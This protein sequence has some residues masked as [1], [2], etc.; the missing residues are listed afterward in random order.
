MQIDQ[1]VELKED[2][3]ATVKAQYL[4]SQTEMMSTLSIEENEKVFLYSEPAEGMDKLP[5]AMTRILETPTTMEMINKPEKT[6]KFH[7]L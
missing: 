2:F 1:V 3:T 7:V 4:M 5:Y 6:V